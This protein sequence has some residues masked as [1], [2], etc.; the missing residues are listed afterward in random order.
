MR[1]REFIALAACASIASSR[2]AAQTA[3]RTHRVGLLTAIGPMT[4]SSPFGAPLMRELTRLGYTPGQNI[5]FERRGAEGHV[6]RLP[7]LVQELVAMKVDVIVALG[8]PPALAAKHASNIPV[9]TIAAGDPVATGL[10]DALARPGGNL[11]GI[12]DVASELTAKR[13]ELLKEIAP[14]LR[15]VA[16]LWNVTDPA[17]TLRYQVSEEAAKAMGIVVQP[18][19]IRDAN[20]FDRA[21]DTMQRELPDAILM[22]SNSLTTP[23]S[24]RVFEFASRHRLPAIYEWDF[25]VRNGGLMSYAMDLEESMARVAS[26]V[27]R[28]LKGA[29][30]ADLPVEQP[31]RF[32]FVINLKTA[33]GLG[34]TVPPTLLA[35]ADEVFE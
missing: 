3:A 29:K 22:V 27:D 8:Y 30:P 33:K 11:T 35:R 32:R 10:V 25:I 14:S 15:R 16:M 5:S 6:D 19:A 18:V 2:I 28:I 9:V 31:T 17:M 34:L 1:R 26:L 23:N 7:Q 21:F 4:D 12:S 24:K 20:D 13:I